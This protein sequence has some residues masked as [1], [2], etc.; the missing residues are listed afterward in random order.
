MCFDIEIKNLEAK[1]LEAGI[2]DIIKTYAVRGFNIV[3]VH[4]VIQ[5][6]PIQTRKN[7]NVRVNVVSKANTYRAK[8]NTY[9]AL[10]DL[11]VL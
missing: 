5:F 10:N 6:E 11:Y 7:I 3:V 1:H 8:A 2:L 9:R 4:V